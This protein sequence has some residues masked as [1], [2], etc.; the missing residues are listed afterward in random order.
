M[1]I[2]AAI[3]QIQ[4]AY[5][6]VYFACHS[7]HQRGRTHDQR[8]SPRDSQLLAH[9]DRRRPT[10]L[11]PLARHM[12]LAASTLSEAV[13]RLERF[14]Y[15]M[16]GPA[17][18]RDRRHVG[19]VLTSKGFGAVLSSSALERPRLRTVLRRLSPRDLS[20]VVEGLTLLASACRPR[21]RQ[22]FPAAFLSGNDSRGL[23]GVLSS[24]VHP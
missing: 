6:Q 15:V 7:R 24:K 16:K 8:L 23:S 5:P 4:F 3:E 9:L 13:T 12:G 17:D 10:S 2:D 14:G 20:A 1:T 11:T 21:P 19:I 18:G 22:S